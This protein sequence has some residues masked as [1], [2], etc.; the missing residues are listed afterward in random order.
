F[1]F[2]TDIC[3]NHF[4]TLKGRELCVIY[5]VHS[6]ENQTRPRLKTYVPID[7]PQVPSVTPPYS[8]ANWMERETYDFYGIRFTRHP[9]LARIL[10]ADEMD[11][12]PLRREYPLEDGRRTDKEDKYFGR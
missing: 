9:N 12:V 11:Y 3:G 4:P 2:L 7:N 5:H 6:M 10:N 8:A 1:T